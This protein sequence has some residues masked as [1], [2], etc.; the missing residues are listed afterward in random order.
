MLWASSS[1]L[2][3]CPHLVESI[4]CEEPA[5]YL[6]QVQQGKCTPNKSS[7]GP[8]TVVQSAKCIS[9]EGTVSSFS[10]TIMKLIKRYWT[11]VFCVVFSTPWAAHYLSS[12]L[13]MINKQLMIN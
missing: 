6:W 4:P 5:C 2:D 1:P 7:C 8:G 3:V 9:A 13:L 12:C 10:N 11:I